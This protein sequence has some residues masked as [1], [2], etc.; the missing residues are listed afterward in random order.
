[1]ERLLIQ[2]FGP[3]PQTV[4]RRLAKASLA[5]VEAWS[6]ALVTAQSLRQVFK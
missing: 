6:D 3:L 5:Q 1:L 2:R 4:H